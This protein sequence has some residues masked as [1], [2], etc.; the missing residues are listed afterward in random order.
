MATLVQ[1]GAATVVALSDKAHEVPPSFH[2]PTVPVEAWAPYADL[3]AAD[4][5]IP[6]NFGCFLVVADGLHVLVDT[7]WGPVAG[8]PGRPAGPGRLLDELTSVG[9]EPGRIDLVVLTHLHPDHLGWNLV[10][11]DGA[12]RPRFPNARYQVPAADWHAY[13]ARAEVHPQ[14]REQGFGLEGVVPL[15]LV[16]GDD[17][18]S[19][20]IRGIATPGHTPG[21]RSLLVR[22]AGE[23]CLILGDLAHT[24]VV[25]QEV[26]WVNQFDWDAAEAVATRR[27]VLDR[28]EA[29]GTLV[30]AGHFPVPSL[31]HFV[32][33]DGRR[34]WR[35]IVIAGSAAG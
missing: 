23:E 13:R 32:R 35:P 20:S 3:L 9:V 27:A 17:A 14:I 29:E 5:C 4:G 6:L 8:P 21:H 26:D 22:S 12:W 25:A 1:V 15:D 18:V 19:P 16:G 7:G 11:E 10:E 31:G 33:V 24:P 34:R 28:L 30:G 2:F